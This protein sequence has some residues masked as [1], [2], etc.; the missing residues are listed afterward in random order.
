MRGAGSRGTGQVP[1][2]PPRPCRFR[3]LISAPKYAPVTGGALTGDKP[4]GYSPAVMI[5]GEA[6]SISSN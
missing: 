2:S 1:R 3:I 5:E 6:V 4:A